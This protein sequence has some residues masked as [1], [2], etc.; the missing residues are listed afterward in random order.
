MKRDP[1]LESESAVSVRLTRDS[2]CAGDDVD[3]P[4]ERQAE[5]P[6]FTD[7]AELAAHLQSGYL[8]RVAGRGHSWSCRLNGRLVAT[9]HGNGERILAQTGE[10]SYEPVNSVHFA[11]HSASW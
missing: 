5:V 2:V 10:L 8:A 3:A 7:P 9:V 6:R 11:Y 4:H 1:V